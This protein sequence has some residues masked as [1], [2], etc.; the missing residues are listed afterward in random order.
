MTG[1]FNRKRVME[2][3]PGASL[4]GDATNFWTPNRRC[5]DALLRDIGFSK[6]HFKHPD[7]RLRRGI[8][9]AERA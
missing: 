9:H 8:F 5:M 7:Y 4:E 2:Y 3:H 1:L 6:I